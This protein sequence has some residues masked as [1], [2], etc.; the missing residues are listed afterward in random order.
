[1]TKFF[2]QDIIMQEICSKLQSLNTKCDQINSQYSQASTIVIQNSMPRA[3]NSSI[4]EKK[5]KE[6]SFS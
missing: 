2:N 6:K 3:S 4:R 5:K 1:M